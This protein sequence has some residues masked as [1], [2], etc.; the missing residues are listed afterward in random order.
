MQ[1]VQGE[2]DEKMDY[3]KALRGRLGSV[4]ATGA[5]LEVGQMVYTTGPAENKPHAIWVYTQV[6]SSPL[7]AQVGWKGWIHRDTTRPRADAGTPAVK[8]LDVVVSRPSKM[9]PAADSNQFQCNMTVPGGVRAR[10]VECEGDKARIEL[11]DVRGLYTNGYVK[12]GQ[13]DDDPCG[14]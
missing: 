7:E 12:R 11:W 13:F 10:L 4:V 9:C 14:H 2:T 6:K 5:V 8:P 1:E 3:R